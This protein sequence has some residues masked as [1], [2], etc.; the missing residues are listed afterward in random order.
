MAPTFSSTSLLSVNASKSWSSSERTEMSL[1][2]SLCSSLSPDSQ[3]CAAD[4]WPSQ[5]GNDRIADN[6]SNSRSSTDP[7]IMTPHSH[8]H[9]GL[10]EDL[11]VHGFANG[12]VTSPQYQTRKR[13]R[14]S[15]KLGNTLAYRLP[16][17]ADKEEEL[18]K[19]LRRRGAQQ[20]QVK[21]SEENE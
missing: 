9:Y 2:Q 15:A 13:S 4:R 19:T 11:S 3:M 12:P 18:P 8:S 16:F 1:S 7:Y 5:S 6:Y 21:K 20:R 10:A 14:Q 17:D